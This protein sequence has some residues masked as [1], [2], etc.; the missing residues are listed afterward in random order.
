MLRHDASL[1]WAVTLLIIAIAVIT[2]RPVGVSGRGLAVVALLVVN[3]VALLARHLPPAFPRR[4]ALVWLTAGV[5]ASAGLLKVSNSGS[6]YLFAYFLVGHAGYRLALK[7]AL[8]VAALSSLLC[9]AVFY[10]YVGPDHQVLTW[11]FGLSTGIPVVAGIL[12]RNRQQAVEAR[13]QAAESAERAARAE[14][15]TA[16]LTERGRIARDV[17][18]VL[19]HSLAGINMHLELADALMDTGD[20]EK[21]RAAH[22]NAQRLV[23]ESLKQAQWTVHALREDSLPLLESLTA[24]IESSGY[25]EVLTV[26]GA[27]RELPAQVTQNVLRIAQEALTNAARHAPGAE[28]AVELTFDAASTSLAVR[29]GPATG[30]ATASVGSGMGLIGMRERVALLGGTLTAGPLTEGPDRGGWQVEAVIRG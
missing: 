2:V 17:H 10:F 9:G 5:V 18:D 28:I 15:R 16:V 26:T 23:R 6:G 7:P 13:L 19:A 24:M 12:G 27:V 30:E 1:Q 11:T 20:L 21:V 22:N 3:S 14:A 4:A 25:R 8:A 29:N